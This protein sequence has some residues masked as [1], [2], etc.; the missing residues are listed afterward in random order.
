MPCHNLILAV[1]NLAVGLLIHQTAKLNSSPNFPA[2]WY[3]QCHCKLNAVIPGVFS[4]LSL[5]VRCDYPLN[6][7]TNSFLR[8][9]RFHYPAIVGVNTTLSCLSGMKLT[10][11]NTLTCME[12]GRWEPDPTKIECKSNKIHET[13]SPSKL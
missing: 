7:V 8:V 13:P 5:A 9:M 1:F 3:S 4:N 10:G 6:Q 12:T 2:I 11:P